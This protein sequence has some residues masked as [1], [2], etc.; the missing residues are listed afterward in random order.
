MLFKGYQINK[1]RKFPGEYI[2]VNLYHFI[3]VFGYTK[4]VKN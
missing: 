4:S 2:V 3:E 1:K